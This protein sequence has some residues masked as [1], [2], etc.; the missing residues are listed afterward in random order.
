MKIYAVFLRLFSAKA[1]STGRVIPKEAQKISDFLLVRRVHY[2]VPKLSD[3]MEWHL[4]KNVSKK[5]VSSYFKLT[6]MLQIL[7][8]VNLIFIHRQNKYSSEI[9]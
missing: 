8:N 3:V 4:M 5:Y 1:R 2:A 7:Q 6:D 9:W